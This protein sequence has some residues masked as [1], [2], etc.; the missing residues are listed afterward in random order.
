MASQKNGG[1][2]HL[3]AAAPSGEHEPQVFRMRLDQP[4]RK[5]LRAYLVFRRLPLSAETLF[6]MAAPDRGLGQLDPAATAVTCGL[7]DGDRV[8]FSGGPPAATRAQ[9]PKD[10]AAAPRE[11]PALAPAEAAAA[12][13][14]GPAALPGQASGCAEE[15][16]E[17]KE[18]RAGAGNAA[19]AGEAPVSKDERAAAGNAATASKEAPQ[20]GARGRARGRG[21]QRAE[22]TGGADGSWVELTPQEA[23]DRAG[24]VPQAHGRE[25]ESGQ[26]GSA[27]AGE[28]ASSPAAAPTSGR[29]GRSGDPDVPRNN[30]R[31]MNISSGP[32]KGW[33]VMAW[34]KDVSNRKNRSHNHE[35]QW[36]VRSPRRRHSYHAFGVASKHSLKHKVSEAVY[37]HIYN[38]VRP[39]LMRLIKDRRAVLEGVRFS[40][41]KAAVPSC[42]PEVK[43][44]RKDPITPVKKPET[45][46]L[47]T[48]CFMALQEPEDA[49]TWACECKAH[50]RR[51]SRCIFGGHVQPPL[52]HLRDRMRIGRGETN[53]VVLESKL[54]PQ[55]I[56]RCHAELLCEDGV[57]QL[58]DSGSTNGMQVNGQSVRKR[59][60]LVSGDIITFGVQTLHPEF[61]YIFEVRPGHEPAPRNEEPEPWMVV[62]PDPA[63]PE[64]AAEADVDRPK[65]QGT[66]DGAEAAGPMDEGTQ[67]QERQEELDGAAWSAGEPGGPDSQELDTMP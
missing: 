34:L 67:E 50:L 40:H 20:P 53:D 12:A 63:K 61:D 13:A 32:A 47:A 58:I 65:A 24:R 60:S 37:T 29:A 22:A 2:V 64:A 1:F 52:V 14:A 28:A 38:H 7:A 49:K 9:A 43:R 51:H 4:L 27:L 16:P 44:A 31:C 23:P 66:T 17:P 3:F 15:A 36:R 21:R 25:R 48:Q 55:M 42:P 5:L 35:V 54:T 45:V 18:L 59:Q 30:I 10:E 19:T 26:G 33:H 11:A 57:F 46:L 8:I 39:E 62:Q 56:S 41:K 6:R